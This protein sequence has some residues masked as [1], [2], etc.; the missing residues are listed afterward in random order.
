MLPPF[1]SS[2]VI[3]L[4]ASRTIASATARHVVVHKIEYIAPS[5]VWCKTL[6]VLIF[7]GTDAERDLASQDGTNDWLRAEFFNQLSSSANALPFDRLPD[8]I[9]YEFD[10]HETVVRDFGGSY[11]LRLR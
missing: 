11:F 10:S 5:E 9:T 2:A 6:A 3:D 7:Y 4:A 1:P 8:E